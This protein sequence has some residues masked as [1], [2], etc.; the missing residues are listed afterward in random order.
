MNYEQ[1]IK[2]CRHLRL[3]LEQSEAAFFL[4]LVE[5][6]EKY[7]PLLKEN[8]CDT[9][10]SFLKTHEL[11]E[12]FRYQSFKEG[13]AKISPKEAL[14]MGAP[15]VMA[16]NKLHDEDNLPKYTDAVQAWSKEH[17]GLTPREETARR[18]LRQVDPRPETPQAVKR[19][20]DATRLAAELQ[21]AKA[22]LRAAERK[23]AKLEKELEA[24]RKKAA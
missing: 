22:Q 1:I 14:V 7:A 6:E 4:G 23:I 11:C 15:A 17:D 24:L 16:L 13:L 3:K 9:F 18:L 21:Q 12:A 2:H 20:N 5:V 8:G 19:Q 10:A